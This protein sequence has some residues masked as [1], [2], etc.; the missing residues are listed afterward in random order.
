VG[1]I[2]PGW[3]FALLFTP[4]EGRTTILFLECAGEIAGK[5]LKKE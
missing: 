2:I 5:F 4:L 1:E 3:L